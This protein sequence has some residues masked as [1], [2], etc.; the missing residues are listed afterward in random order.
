MWEGSSWLFIILGNEYIRGNR[1]FHYQECSKTGA[2][3]LAAVI[4]EY[5][6]YATSG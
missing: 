3:L 1:Q 4:L 6:A 2:E 5:A